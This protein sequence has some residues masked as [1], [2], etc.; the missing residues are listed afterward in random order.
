MT[1]VSSLANSPSLDKLSW[2]VKSLMAIS[3]NEYINRSIF[4]KSLMAIL[5]KKY[6]NHDTLVNLHLQKCPLKNYNLA[7]LQP[8]KNIYVQIYH[9]QIHSM[10]KTSTDTVA[11]RAK[12]LHCVK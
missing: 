6:I 11:T 12:L 4:V 1:S 3:M 2:T 10:V 9:L 5:E 7:N 8:C